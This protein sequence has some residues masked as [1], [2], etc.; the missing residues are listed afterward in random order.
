M[1]REKLLLSILPC[2]VLSLSACGSGGSS[3]ETELPDL[4]NVRF[5]TLNEVQLRRMVEID[6]ADDGPFHMVNLIKFKEKADYADGRETD[7]T[8]READALYAPQEFL[9]GI[10]AVIVFV[11]AVESNLITRDGTEWEQIGIVRYPSRALFLEM[12]Q[13]EEFRA[14]AIHKDAGVEKSLVIVADLQDSVQLPEPDDIPNPATPDD[15]PVAVAH[16]L[17][18]NEIADYGPGSSEPQRSG[19]EAIALYEQGATGI[20]LE[21]GGGPLAWF[22]IEGVFIGDGRVWDEFRINLFPSHAAFDAVVADPTRQAGEVHRQAAIHD[23][24]TTTNQIIINRLANED[25]GGGDVL[26][27]TDNGTGAI[28]SDDAG[29]QGQEADK[30]LRDGGAGFCTVEGCTAGTCEGP[31]VCCHDCAD[32]AADL[33]PFENSACF[34][35]SQTGQL[36]SGAMCTCD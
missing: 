12:V 20:A 32:F 19:E 8:G 17:A 5:G 35:P 18:Y 33:L 1:P 26:E 4:G 3:G 14:R 31:Y 29:C 21:Q 2:L 6:A 16:L 23:T 27:V 13:N 25:T 24:Y 15:R 30:C 9:D 7:L 36:T 11:G 28:C 22:E 10:G 34:P